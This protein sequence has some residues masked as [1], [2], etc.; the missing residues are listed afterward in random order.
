MVLKKNNSW[1]QLYPLQSGK[2]SC[3]LP[4]MLQLWSQS[5][6]S[7]LKNLIEKK[8]KIKMRI[9]INQNVFIHVDTWFWCLMCLQWAFTSVFSV[10]GAHSAFFGGCSW[11]IMADNSVKGKNKRRVFYSPPSSSSSSDSSDDRKVDSNNSD[12]RFGL[13]RPQRRKSRYEYDPSYPEPRPRRTLRPTFGNGI[14]IREDGVPPTEVGC[15]AGTEVT[16]Q[17]EQRPRGRVNVRRGG[18]RRG[19]SGSLPERTRRRRQRTHYSTRSSSKVDSESPSQKRTILSWLIDSRVVE[20][21]AKI[22]YKNEAGEQILQGVLTGDGIWCSCCNTVITVSEFQLHAGDEPNRPYQR[23]FI[24]ETGLSLLTCQAEAW[25]QQGIPEL[26]GYHLIEPREDVS[27]KY[28]DACVVCADGG[29]LI[30]CDKCPSTYH[31][32][33]LQMEV[34]TF[35]F[36]FNFFLFFIR[37]FSL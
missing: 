36:S 9:E 12:P 15:S 25:N 20:N 37:S 1:W 21:N 8:N 28:D 6:T 7:T 35:S 29:N 10:S 2:A 13:G 17:R 34:K 19:P 23:I 5:Y 24:S 18:G 30:C 14:N 32:S 11:R 22:V 3:L 26:Q 4:L 31:I 33:C 16:T 27:D